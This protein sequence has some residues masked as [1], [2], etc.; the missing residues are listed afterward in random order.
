MEPIKDGRA[1]LDDLLE[2]LLEKGILLNLD[3]IIGI[4][5]IP[6]IG[7]NLRAAIAA[8]ETMIEYGMMEVWDERI[9]NYAESRL[10]RKRPPLDDDERSLFEARGSIWYSD[11]AYRAWR[12]ARI[13]L[14]DRRMILYRKE[15]FEVISQFRPVD[16][17][18]VWLRREGSLT[19]KTETILHFEFMDGT[20]CLLRS[21]CIDELVAHLEQLG[22]WQVS[23]G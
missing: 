3:L 7:I 4:A 5:D 9:R 15:P 12:P 21:S 11:G 1:T 22:G 10:A 23:L 16:V 13:L 20:D 14:T 2:R 6:L 17:A 19:G 18:T 8:I